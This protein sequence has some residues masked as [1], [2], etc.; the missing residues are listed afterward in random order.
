MILF[1]RKWTIHPARL[2][3]CFSQNAGGDCFCTEQ[4]FSVDMSVIVDT[5]DYL[6]VPILRWPC[7]A[8]GTFGLLCGAAAIALVANPTAPTTSSNLTISS[9]IPDWDFM[10]PSLTFR[11]TGRRWAGD[12]ATSMHGGSI[13]GQRN[14]ERKSEVN[15]RELNRLENQVVIGNTADT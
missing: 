2:D 10:S 12:V 4:Q 15:S 6:R 7:R 3:F 8:G 13:Y 14:V 1:P 9:P 5:H 11:V